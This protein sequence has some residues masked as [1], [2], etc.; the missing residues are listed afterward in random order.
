MI[1]FTKKMVKDALIDMK[2]FH[3]AQKDLHDKFG[4][5]FNENLGR[6]GRKTNQT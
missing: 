5:D 3:D 6:R 2:E 4:I 1:P